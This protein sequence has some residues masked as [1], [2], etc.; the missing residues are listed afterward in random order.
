MNSTVD[1]WAKEGAAM[2]PVDQGSLTRME[3]LNKVVPV[4][5]K[6]LARG[7]VW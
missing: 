3:R 1:H 2:H 7:A 4:I 5:A 6:F